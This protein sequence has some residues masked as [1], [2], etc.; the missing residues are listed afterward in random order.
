MSFGNYRSV[1]GATG[2]HAKGE[3]E[4]AS[5]LF[6]ASSFAAGQNWRG[7]KPVINWISTKCFLYRVCVLLMLYTNPP[8]P[9]PIGPGMP[10]WGV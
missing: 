2:G 9:A 7:I 1:T 4:Q 10:H 3:V 6:E 5:T 8:P